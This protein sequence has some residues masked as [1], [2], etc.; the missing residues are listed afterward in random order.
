MPTPALAGTTV[1]DFSTVGPAARASRI[2]SDYGA[3]VVKVGAVPRAGG[4]QIIPPYYAYSGH[5][6]MKRV[7]LDLKAPEGRQAFLTL[8]A[9]A[10]VVIES[11]RPGVADRLGVG[12]EDVRAVRPEIVYCSTSG[13]GQSGPY[14]QWA[15]HDINYLAL[16]GYLDCSERA[17]DGKPPLP[18]A[19]VADAAG[20][21][22]QAAMAVMAALVRRS[23][24]GEGAYLD[25][26]IT[27]GVLSLMSLYIDEYLAT[28]TVPGPGHYILTGR[29]ACYDTYRCADGRW[30]AVGAI[31]PHFYENLCRRL[32]CEQWIGHQLDDD[33]QDQIRADFR[34]AFATRPRDEWVAELAPNDTCVAPVYSVPELV[35]DPHLTARGVI[36]EAHHEREG[37]FRQLGTLLAGT[38][39]GRRH[40]EVRDAGE[41]DTDDLLGAA[42]FSAERIRAL[43]E[44]GVVA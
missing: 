42:G 13:Y 31:E 29:Y 43:R 9:G 5:R 40:F 14:S 23:S 19:T 1:L 6:D 17:P 24:T 21:G 36:A 16:G 26:S 15:G 12:Y 41:T 27:D 10:D 25:V 34:A 8:A 2:L 37:T 18:G 22:M 20:G 39:T 7:R 35:N 32:G 30:V 33:V 3:T 44:R 28:G 11:F 38:D 4:V